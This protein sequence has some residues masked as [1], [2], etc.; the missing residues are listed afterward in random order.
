MGP[1]GTLATQGALIWALIWLSGA[2][3]ILLLPPY[4]G[5]PALMLAMG[6]MLLAPRRVIMEFPISFSVI[7]VFTVAIAS[8][9]WTIDA[10]ATIF[11]LRTL[12]PAMIALLIAAGLLTLRDLSDAFIWT[13]R[14]VVVVTYAALAAMPETRSH[15]SEVGGVDGYAGWHGLFNHKNS[16]MAF[17]VVAIP[18]IL[19]FHR[20][21]IVKWATL[22]SIGVLLVGSTSATGISAGFFVTVAWLW[23]RIYWN[24]SRS[25]SRNSTL[26]FLISVLASIGVAAAALASIATVT[27]AYGKDTTLSGRTLIWEASLDAFSRRPWLGYG[28]DALFWQDHLSPETAEI[29]RQVGFDNFHAHNG[30]LQ[31][32]LEVGIVGTVIFAVLWVSTF[33]KGWQAIELQ[34]DLGIWVV[35]IMSGNFLVSLSEDVFFGPWIALFGMFKMLLMRRDESLRRRGWTEGPVDKWAYR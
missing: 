25:D 10:G 21:G 30:I 1:L 31:V 16:M 33:W 29:W 5:I 15:T 28:F 27:S 34:P 4:M 7:G 18:T 6:A 19:V 8:V 20:P 11:N 32:M 24:Q 23:L 14:I 2:L 3:Q 12:M 22:V 26:L 17:L 35:A 9:A 13:I